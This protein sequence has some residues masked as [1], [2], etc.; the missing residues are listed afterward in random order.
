MNNR[1]KEVILWKRVGLLGL[2]LT[3][4]P[5]GAHGPGKPMALTSH[6]CN[7]NGEHASGRE[8]RLYTLPAV[9]AGGEYPLCL[10]VQNEEPI[11]L[12]VTLAMVPGQID[13][14][15]RSLCRVALLPERGGAW[16]LEGGADGRYHLQIPPHDHRQHRFTLRIQTLPVRPSATHPQAAATEW[17]GCLLV[18]G[19]PAVP[20]QGEGHKSARQLYRIQG[21]VAS[22]PAEEGRRRS[23]EAHP[24]DLPRHPRQTPDAQGTPA[25]VPGG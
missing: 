15:G 8:V 23:E 18:E 5:L 3:A 7:A 13:T 12:V 22:E 2:L 4:H 16:L 9:K 10:T 17:I 1:R 11:P 6:W 25:E 19:R 21:D 20:E 24:G 14:H